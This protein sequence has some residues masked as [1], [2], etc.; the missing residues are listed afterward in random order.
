MSLLTALNT[1]ITNMLADDISMRYFFS[2]AAQASASIIAISVIFSVMT[3]QRIYAAMNELRDGL[4]KGSIR[5]I[6]IYKDKI[7]EDE[8]RKIIFSVN[9]EEIVT[10][11]KNYVDNMVEYKS[12]QKN[13]QY[14]IR[15]YDRLHK[16][17]DEICKKSFAIVGINLFLLFTGLIFIFLPAF[18]MFKKEF[19]FIYLAL[20]LINVIL[21]GKFLRSLV[22]VL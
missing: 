16:D 19:F 12:D 4:K 11:I 17:T 6:E 3:L 2:A 18:E 21:T 20:Y 10:F 8:K 7:S 14:L 5:V 22:I 1:T 13:L 15:N 9:A